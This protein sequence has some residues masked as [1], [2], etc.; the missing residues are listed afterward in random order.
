M[1]L[2]FFPFWLWICAQLFSLQSIPCNSSN[3][4]FLLRLGCKKWSYVYI[5][6][7]KSTSLPMS[8][9]INPL[10]SKTGTLSPYPITC[11]HLLTE[12]T[13][14]E[15]LPLAWSFQRHNTWQ[16]TSSQSPSM[17]RVHFHK[18]FRR[19]IP[20]GDITGSISF[21]H[22]RCLGWGVAFR[23]ELASLSLI[24]GVLPLLGITGENVPFFLQ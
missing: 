14:C 6:M 12:P 4:T 3:H 5:F 13:T 8:F 7:S 11:C 24:F 9:T 16:L 21:H 20:I 17:D 22:H 23:W 15:L 10:F 18:S 19:E 2:F 1:Q